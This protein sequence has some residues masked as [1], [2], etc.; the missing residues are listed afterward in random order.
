MK[1]WVVMAAVEYEAETCV[2]VFSSRDLAVDFMKSPNTSIYRDYWILSAGILDDP[3]SW[4]E[5][6]RFDV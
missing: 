6:E 5:S 3:E 4:S 2:G 1:V